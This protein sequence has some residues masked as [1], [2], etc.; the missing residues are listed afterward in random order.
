[1]PC[2]TP[3]GVMVGFTIK[4]CMECSFRYVLNAFRRHGRVHRPGERRGL[5]FML[6]ST[7]FGVMVGFTRFARGPKKPGRSAQRLSASWSGSR[8]VVQDKMAER[9]CAQRLS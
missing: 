3:F 1:M 4:L 7:P 8:K 2:S 9:N 5:T 6:C